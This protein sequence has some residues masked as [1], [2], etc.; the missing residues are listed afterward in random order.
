MLINVYQKF[1]FNSNSTIISPTLDGSAI[2]IKSSDKIINYELILNNVLHTQCNRYMIEF[3]NIIKKKLWSK[4]KSES[5]KIVLN[6]LFPNN[7]TDIIEKYIKENYYLYCFPFG[8]NINDNLS[9]IIFNNFD[10][11]KI[12]LLTQNNIY[13]GN[14]IVKNKNMFKIRNGIG[15]LFYL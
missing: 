14:I 2:Y 11:I 8:I 15:G 4:Y 1:I 10:N 7:I 9:T 6:K 12:N 3:N 13:D 5:I